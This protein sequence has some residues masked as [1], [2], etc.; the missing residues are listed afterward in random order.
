MAEAVSHFQTGFA[1]TE[2]NP[3]H[4][5]CIKQNIISC[6]LNIRAITRNIPGPLPQYTDLTHYCNC[7]L[8]YLDHFTSMLVFGIC[9]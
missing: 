7:A 5:E 2:L 9:V 8:L 3:T 6:Y 1:T 4:L